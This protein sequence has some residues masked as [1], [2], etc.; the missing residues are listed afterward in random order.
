[1]GYRHVLWR[2]SYICI[3]PGKSPVPRYNHPSTIR[4]H[5][6]CL[7]GKNWDFTEFCTL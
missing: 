3:L 7:K 6:K 4:C 5:I 1:M 2:L